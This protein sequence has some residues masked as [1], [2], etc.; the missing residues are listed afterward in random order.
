MG[1]AFLVGIGPGG[2]L[3]GEARDALNASEVFY[4]Y[5]RYLDQIAPQYPG[6]ECHAFSMRQEAERCRAVLDAA[7]KGKTAALI[8]G[9]DPGVYSLAG[10]V[11]E[12]APAYPAAE[13]V[14]VPGVTAALAGSALLGAPLGHDFCLISLSDLLTPWTVIEKRL[15]CAAAGDFVICLYN[16]ASRRRRD[17]LSRACDVLLET[18][19]PDTLCGWTRNLGRQGQS[20]GL[21]PLWELRAFQAD[22]ATTLFI[23]STATK[24]IQGRMVTPRGY[25]L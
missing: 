14:I 17:H 20:W 23:G 3:T 16:P 22:M 24:E 15:R 21:L 13:T 8:C 4:G 7:Q 12:L 11:L 2:D 19:D 18:L 9:G 1:T 10:L 6:K 5:G 25:T